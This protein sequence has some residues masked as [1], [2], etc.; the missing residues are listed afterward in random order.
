MRPLSKP[1]TPSVPHRKVMP[2]GTVKAVTSIVNRPSNLAATRIQA[3]W[4]GA[5]LRRKLS[6]NGMCPGVVLVRF[7]DAPAWLLRACGF[8]FDPGVGHDRYTF[9]FASIDPARHEIGLGATGTLAE[10]LLY[11]V[12]S[13]DVVAVIN[14]GFFN[15]EGRADPSAPEQ[16]SI[17]LSQTADAV[18]PHLPIPGAYARDYVHLI[19]DDGSSLH[20]APVLGLGGQAAFTKEHL[21][22][23]RFHV[24]PSFDFSKEFIVP[25]ALAHAAD[26]NPRA[27]ASRP[28]GPGP[29]HTRLVVGLAK[30]RA[31][32]QGYSLGQWSELVARIDRM[33]SPPNVSVNLDGGSSTALA[34]RERDGAM[35]VV[36]QAG[37]GRPVANVIQV[38]VRR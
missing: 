1:D 33:E 2:A 13:P 31:A 36:A 16:A 18:M 5:K 21:S 23:P 34:V 38:K 17:G 12:G 8:H 3:A 19:L 11:M 32:G 20:T 9:A 28:V 26:A 37:D 25:G 7:N 4:R 30:R 24:P 10:P 22:A 29:G 14:G 15:M 6:V 27:A 35:M